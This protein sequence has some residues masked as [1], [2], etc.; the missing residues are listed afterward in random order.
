MFNFSQDGITIASMVDTRKSNKDKEYSIKIRVTYRRERKYFSTGKTIDKKGW[1]TL[2]NTRSRTAAETREAIQQSFDSV[3][4]VVVGLIKEGTFSFDLLDLRIG[5]SASG[6]L[7]LALESKIAELINESRAGTQIYYQNVLSSV[8]RFKGK[9]IKFHSINVDWLKKYERW[10]LEAGLSYSTI[11]MYMRG[12]RHMVNIAVRDGSIK[13]ND[14]PF[15]PGKYIIPTGEGRKIALTMADIK[16]VMSYTDGSETTERYRDLWFLSYLLNGINVGD[17][18]RLKDSNIWNGEIRWYRAKTIRTSNQKKEVIAVVTPEVSRI[19]DRWGVP[20]RRRDDYIF[21]Y[22]YG[23]DTAMKEKQTILDLVKRMNKK[24]K[25][26]ADA[27][28]IPGKFGETD[29][30]NSV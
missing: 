19:I 6:T 10:L 23:R 4:R 25:E 5:R 14:Y 17:L 28:E 29:H 12:I 30:L 3:K 27:L 15:G 7:N 21:P 2:P 18:I 9:S 24:L 1:D 11:G 13:P 26:I 22:L 8:E 16:K 20:G